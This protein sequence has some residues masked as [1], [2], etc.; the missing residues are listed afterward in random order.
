MSTLLDQLARTAAQPISRS[1]ALK[2]IG[3]A[4]F[5]GGAL[6]AA[7]AS[8]SRRVRAQSCPPC[9]STQGQLCSVPRGVGCIRVCCPSEQPVCC[10]ARD[11]VRCCYPGQRCGQKTVGDFQGTEC[12]GCPTGKEE[13]GGICCSEGSQCADADLEYCCRARQHVCR[14][15]GTVNCCDRNEAC[16]NGK[17]CPPGLRCHRGRCTHCPPKTRK[18]G[19]SRCCE[20]GEACC[21]GRCC[22]KK[23]KCCNDDHCCDKNEKCCGE[24]CCGASEKCCGDHCCPDDGDCCGNG[25]CA[26]GRTCARHQ[27]TGRKTCCAQAHLIRS[28]AGLVC[29]ADTDVAV[30]NRCCPRSNPNCNECDPPCRAGESCRS[31]YCLPI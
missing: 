17:C 30:G 8:A 22:G 25:C 14:G 24:K 31:G 4:L 15:G 6:R 23:Q 10:T 7:P 9:T 16:C 12:L 19:N 2:L 3:G 11:E 18:C 20:K 1:H 13:C 29:C 26:R 28:P 27:R 21:N 5:S